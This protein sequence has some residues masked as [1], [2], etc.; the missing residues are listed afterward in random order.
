MFCIYQHIF[1]MYVSCHI[2][3]YTVHFV[4]VCVFLLISL[5]RRLHVGI[6]KVSSAVFCFLQMSLCRIKL[7]FTYDKRCP[8]FVKTSTL[9]INI[10]TKRQSCMLINSW[11]WE[12]GL[13]WVEAVL[14]AGAFILWSLFHILQQILPW[15]QV[16][17]SSLC[18]HIKQWAAFFLR[19]CLSSPRS[20]NI[21]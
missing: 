11:K 6:N 20:Y 18:F 12:R 7:L 17:L 19:G 16:V 9:E 3:V 4:C 14:R 13:C 10:Q 2:Y 21:L 5:Q 15:C 8:K 1:Y